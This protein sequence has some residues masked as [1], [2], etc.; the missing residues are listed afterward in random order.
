M[1]RENISD[2]LGGLD[3][4]MIAPVARLRGSYRGRKRWLR[5][6]VAAACLCFLCVE[7]ALVYRMNFVPVGD[8]ESAQPAD[9][10]SAEDE[11]GDTE[12]GTAN[13]PDSTAD[14]SGERVIAPESLFAKET[15]DVSENGLIYQMVP[16]GGYEAFYE[17]IC[18]AGSDVLAESLGEGLDGAEGFYR[19][20]GHG[21]LQYLIS[22]NEKTASPADGGERYLLWKFESFQTENSYPYRDVLRLIYGVEQADAIEKMVVTAPTFDNTDRGMQIQ[23]EIGTYEVTDRDA[24]E[25]FYEI[26]SGMVCYGSGHWELIDYGSLDIP[27]DGEGGGES[28]RKG[29]Y[30]TLVTDKG[31]EIDRLKYTAVSDMFYE[32]SGVAYER[33][34]GEQAKCVEQVLGI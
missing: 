5:Y 25:T 33:L 29:R 28:I 12:N 32:Y 34:S 6:A 1:R 31:C 13:A 9:N 4:K 21:D 20:K 30:L 11:T 24:I 26:I 18:S 10:V 22:D 8:A 7:A 27:T 16:V 2:A 17:G 23:K 3:E 19:L 15:G 14:A